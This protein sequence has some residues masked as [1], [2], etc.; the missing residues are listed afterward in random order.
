MA[1]EFVWLLHQGR[2]LVSRSAHIPLS[3]SLL[4]P[5][6]TAST[7]EMRGTRE[8]RLPGTPGHQN[9]SR[10]PF[11]NSRTPAFY[12]AR[13]HHLYPMSRFIINKPLWRVWVTT[14]VAAL[15]IIFLL[16]GLHWRFSSYTPNYF[17]SPGDIIPGSEPQSDRADGIYPEQDPP[18]GA[19]TLSVPLDQPV[20]PESQG[21]TNHHGLSVEEAANA[22]LGVSKH[23]EPHILSVLPLHPLLT[24]STLIDARSQ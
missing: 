12:H 10:F 22:T 18:T 17:N 23:A 21:K 24:S 4:C 9:F 14:I 16:T 11:T 20:A 2:K 15:G 19:P 6:Y 7:W 8:I 13:S 5:C 1:R 3:V